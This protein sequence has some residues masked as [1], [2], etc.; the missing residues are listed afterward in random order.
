MSAVL[1][2]RLA[3]PADAL[4]A[5]VAERLRAA[6][7]LTIAATTLSRAAIAA[8]PL[9]QRELTLRVDA[10]DPLAHAIADRIAVDAREIGFD[11]QGAGAGRTGASSRTAR[12]VRVRVPNRRLPIARWRRLI[13]TRTANVVDGRRRRQPRFRRPPR[14]T[15]SIRRRRQLLERCVIVPIVHLP[16]I[17]GFSDRV[18]TWNRPAVSASGA[19]NLAD[20]WLEEPVRRETAHAAVRAGRR[21]RRGRRDAGHVDS[22]GERAP[23]VRD[24]RRAADRSAGRAVPA[25]VRHRGEDRQAALDRLAST[26]L[27]RRD[28][29]RDR[30]ARHRLRALTS[31]RPRP[32]RRPRVSTSSTSSPPTG[33]SFRRRTGRRGSA[34]GMRGRSNRRDG[35]S[36]RDAFLQ[37][38][39]LPQ[40]MAL[41]LVAVRERRGGRRSDLSRRRPRGST[42]TSSSRSCCRRDARAAVPQCRARS[43]ARSSCRRVGQRRQ[44]AQLEPLIARVRQSR[45]EATPRRSTG[46]MGRRR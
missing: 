28:R 25:R 32:S 26:D 27:V 12:L 36:G 40:E 14:S 39:E 46:P 5:A 38:V 19:W 45:Q 24:A 4:A 21:R 1:L 7:R 43:L 29:A 35:A 6:V 41:G 31:T 34:T 42:S 2:Q 15:P 37:A 20:V 11:H 18:D 8:L 23:F 13:D 10:S 9:D 22:L 33:R 17:Y 16:E 3:E 44:A 30:T